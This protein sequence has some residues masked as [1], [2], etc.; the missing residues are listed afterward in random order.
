[1]CQIS[2]VQ[3]LTATLILMNNLWNK[4]AKNGGIDHFLVYS[5]GGMELRPMPMVTVLGPPRGPT[6]VRLPFEFLFALR[7]P[8]GV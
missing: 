2:L 4:T 8:G 5:G 6:G 1:M 7:V 3:I